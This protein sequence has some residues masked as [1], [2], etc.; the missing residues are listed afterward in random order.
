MILEFAEFAEPFLFFVFFHR[1]STMIGEFTEFFEVIFFFVCALGAI[2]STFKD[3]DQDSVADGTLGDESG[4]DTECVE[5][6]TRRRSR[7][8]YN[9][10]VFENMQE[11]QIPCHLFH[12]QNDG[13][14]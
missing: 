3:S 7:S 9:A 10:E 12:C 6:P 5:K 13:F 8:D 2:S 1:K 14:A 11:K 4:T